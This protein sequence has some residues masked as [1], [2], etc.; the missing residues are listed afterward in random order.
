MVKIPTF[1]NKSISTKISKSVIQAPNIAK[2][3]TLVGKSVENLGK[4]LLK[5]AVA[6]QKAKNQYEANK[7]KQAAS[8]EI[9]KY[10]QDAALDLQTF[11]A[12]ENYKTT[13][14]EIEEDLKNKFDIAALRI[15][16]K[17][18]VLTATSDLQQFSAD[19]I[20]SMMT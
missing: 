3:S 13:V 15:K 10:K 9:A 18:E 7:A 12:E 2:T 11:K 17:N 16:Q 6:D 1:E 8:F 4:T 5:S 20:D 14:F 19:T